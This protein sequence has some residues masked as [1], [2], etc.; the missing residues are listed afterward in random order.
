MWIQG[1]GKM[2][3]VLQMEGWSHPHCGH[4]L[5]YPSSY[6]S[7]LL[8]THSPVLPI[9]KAAPTPL[10]HCYTHERA[11][12]DL[13][14]VNLVPPDT[15]VKEPPSAFL[16]GLF[17]LAQHHDRLGNSV[18]AVELID[19]AIEHTPTDVQLYMLRARIYK[20]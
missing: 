17:M 13:C 14:G 6:P 3:A 8:P 2:G 18:R 1:G 7:P 15:G 4:I 20:V 16:W 5:M 19:E 11:H 9:C 10:L 12:L